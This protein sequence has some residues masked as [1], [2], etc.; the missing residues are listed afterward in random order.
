[1]PMK[2]I[3][4]LLER[5]LHEY[6]YFEKL[7]RDK[8]KELAGYEKLFL[9]ASHRKSGNTY[10]SIRSKSQQ[11]STNKKGSKSSTACNYKYLG[12]SAESEVEKIKE[13]HR[14]KATIPVTKLCIKILKKMILL[15]DQ[16]IASSDVKIAK[17]YQTDKPQPY[18]P[19]KQT[20]QQWLK[21]SVRKSKNNPPPHPENLTQPTADGNFVRSKSEALIYNFLLSLGLTFFYERP[22]VTKSGIKYPDFTILSEI[23]DCTIIIIEHQGMMEVESYRHNHADK[24]YDYLQINLIPG[25]NIFYTYDVN[26]KGPDLSYIRE[27]IERHVRPRTQ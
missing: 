6:E 3:K 18:M 22:L 20:H 27:I 9:Q 10:Y 17:I 19:K 12:K 13:A 16:F 21:E 1:M 25:V 8:L 7:Q 23:D 24:I 11:A 15:A 5:K 2:T 14:L 26:G 4:S